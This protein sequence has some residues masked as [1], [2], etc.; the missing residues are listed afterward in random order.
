LNVLAPQRMLERKDLSVMLRICA[1]LF[2]TDLDVVAASLHAQYS[3]KTCAQ[4]VLA[5]AESMR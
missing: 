4:N 5:D 2:D 3:P 1:D